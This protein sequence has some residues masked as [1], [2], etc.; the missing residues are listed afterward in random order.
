VLVT[1]ASGFIGTALARRLAGEGAVV[2]GVSR[3]SRTGGDC[4]RW[5]QAD[6]TDAAQARKVLEAVRPDLVF[7][8]GALVTGRRDLQLVLSTFQANLAATVNLLVAAT[9]SGVSRV[10]HAGSMEE[11]PPDGAWPVCPSPY[12]AAKLAAGAYARMFQALYGT[13]SVW[14]R[15]FMV[16][17]P[18]QSDHTKLIPYS[19]LSSLRGQAPEVRSPDRRVDW[20]YVDDVVD[21]V[22]ATSVADGIEGRT[23]D[24]GTGRLVTVGEVVQEIVQI[25]GGEATPRRAA[26]DRPLEG[27]CVADVGSTTAATGWRPRTSLEEGLRRTVRWYRD[28]SRAGDRR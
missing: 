16:Y 9:E 6:L 7:N 22:V 11:P 8:L 27:E 10:L 21:A 17:G 15:I 1:G 23:F 26:A 24:V 25:V 12:A 3:Q 14:L 20:I 19:I 2:H 18:G 28:Q 4:V 13:P 5:W